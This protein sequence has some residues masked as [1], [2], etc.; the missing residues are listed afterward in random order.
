MYAEGMG[1]GRISAMFPMR[2]R[3]VGRRPLG[4]A[5]TEVSRA[6][7]LRDARER[8]LLFFCLAGVLGLALLVLL[9]NAPSVL[10]EAGCASDAA[11]QSASHLLDPSNGLLD[12][13]PL[14]VVHTYTGAMTSTYHISPNLPDG[15]PVTY[16]AANFRQTVV[17]NSGEY[18]VVEIV[19]HSDLATNVA[20]PLDPEALPQEALDQLCPQPGWIQSDD[21]AIMAQ[22]TELVLGVSRQDVAV[23]RVLA[24]VRAHTRYELGNTA[25]DASR[26]FDS[27]V[28]ERE[29][30]ATL[31][32]ALL[33]AAGIP[34]RYVHGAMLPSDLVD[35][36]WDSPH[37]TWHAWI[38]VYYPDVGWVA[39]DPQFTV[40]WIDSAHVRHGFPNVG[41]S[42]V[43][44]TRVSHQAELSYVYDQRTSHP[45]THD[46]GLLRAAFTAGGGACPLRTDLDGRVFYVTRDEP[47][48][49]VGGT[50]A[51]DRTCAAAWA[52][53]E[54]VP[55]LAFA[56]AMG[57]AETAVTMHLDAT[58]LASGS[59]VA[60]VQ[61]TAP[62]DPTCDPPA[63]PM[64][65]TFTIELVVRQAPSILLP[66]LCRR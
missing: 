47:Q 42:H 37:G 53:T 44:I 15:S 32:C 63:R 60:A 56:P 23:A 58:D 48:R 9:T 18:T 34:S 41:T 2:R 22:A 27:G 43:N 4:A 28:A 54:A 17:D 49:Q 39:S 38:E 30:F 31:S 16:T 29:G 12:D 8:L 26:V 7:P 57:E 6:S 45:V 3:L 11:P 24:W 55:W 35:P 50:V 25:N 1:H 20:F 59:Y 14:L 36:P 40:N 33:R 19:A 46:H 51:N 5:A 66:F 62:A 61:L 65:H 64:T 21:P 13:D 10:G 52:L